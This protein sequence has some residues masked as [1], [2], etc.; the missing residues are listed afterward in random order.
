MVIQPCKFLFRALLALFSS[1][2]FAFEDGLTLS[3]SSWADK[4]E[5][6]EILSRD[7][8]DE[9]EQ[10]LKHWVSGHL[11][12]WPAEN[13]L[14]AGFK[15]GRKYELREL[16]SGVAINV[17]KRKAVNK[18]K[19]NNKLR[20]KIK[21]A[22][23]YRSLSSSDASKRLTAIAELKRKPDYSLL[24]TLLRL[25]EANRDLKT[26]RDLQTLVGLVYLESSKSTE[27][28]EGIKRLTDN[29]SSEAK[30]GLSR[31][32]LREDISSDVRALGLRTIRDIE[33]QLSYWG[34]AQDIVF[35]ISLGSILLLAAVGLA[36]TFGV[37]GV[38]NMAHGEFIMLGAYTTFVVQQIIPGGSATALFVSIPAAFIVAGVAGILL[39]KS[40]IRHLYGRPLETLL[41]T[42]GVSLLLQQMVRSIFGPLNQAVTSPEIL[43]GSLVVNAAFAITYNRVFV[44]IFAA[45][46]MVGLWLLMY[47]TPF[48]VR[49][50]AVTMNRG[51]AA[52][53]GIRSQRMDALAFGLGSGVAGMA[54][55]AISQLTNV[56]P[57][58]GQ[59]YIV[60]SFMVVVFGGV[61]N[62]FG[63]AIAAIGLGVATK[64]VE[65]IIGP[66]LA[67]IVI[68]IFIILF[69]QRRPRGLFALRGR[70]VEE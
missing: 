40:V 63:T 34:H 51:M 46:V 54:G 59:A 29:L 49:L 3:Q 21:Q 20:S 33:K 37:M 31:L 44:I 26:S 6:I 22:L 56:G 35:G 60:D 39:E 70:S 36:I 11:F 42:V 69:I 30:E 9:A 28:I 48:G 1:A 2:T 10:I 52:S 67:K 57:N 47:R 17:V 27:Q 25:E 12:Y 65:P 62:L 13:R 4:G 19:V 50:R 7:T 15:Q 61:G 53:M 5:W 18:I 32:L 68:L 38:I 43:S 16:I 55:V 66:V 45:L 24:H 64:I 14:V 23:A 41:A 8:T 58:L